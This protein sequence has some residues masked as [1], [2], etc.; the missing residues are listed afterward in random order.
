MDCAEEAVDKARGWA[1]CKVSG[2][3]LHGRSSKAGIHDA[4]LTCMRQ[5]SLDE[6][7]GS[8]PSLRTSIV[9]KIP[10]TEGQE[11]LATELE[12]VLHPHH[13]DLQV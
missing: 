4:E 3:G 10:R 6:A 9:I 11:E 7:I 12:K 13:M 2:T 8:S 1:G 5:R